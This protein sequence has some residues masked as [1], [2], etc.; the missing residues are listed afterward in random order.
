MILRLQ[1]NG[2]RD[3][4]PECALRCTVHR[5]NLLHRWS[6]PGPPSHLRRYRQMPP[7]NAN[8]VLPLQQTSNFRVFRRSTHLLIQCPAGSRCSSAISSAGSTVTGRDTAL[9]AAHREQHAEQQKE[10][11]EASSSRDSNSGNVSGCSG[12]RGAQPLCRNT[13]AHLGIAPWLSRTAPSCAPG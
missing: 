7:C 10:K 11:Q 13:T 9:S 4:G 8:N 3:A 6:G 5:A 12:R 2:P 1:A